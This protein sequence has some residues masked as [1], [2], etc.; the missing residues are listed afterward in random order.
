MASRKSRTLHR[1]NPVIL[2]FLLCCF[3][4]YF[5]SP[6]CFAVCHMSGPQQWSACEQHTP[7]LA[8]SCQLLSQSTL[9]QRS[10]FFCLLPQHTWNSHH[11]KS[12]IRERG[13]C[14]QTAFLCSHAHQRKYLP[15]TGPLKKGDQVCGFCADSTQML[16]L[17]NSW[18]HIVHPQ[19]WFDLEACNCTGW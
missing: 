2:G 10:Q 3:S 14:S 5:F 19:L 15:W 9:L 12:D 6:V 11:L 1:S 17:P 13:E 4:L 8:W 7:Q 18:Q 16:W